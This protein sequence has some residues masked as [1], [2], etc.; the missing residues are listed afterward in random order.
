MVIWRHHVPLNRLYLQSKMETGCS[1]KT[2]ISIYKPTGCRTWKTTTW[3][4]HI[5]SRSGMWCHMPRYA[6]FGV[7]ADLTLAVSLHCRTSHSLRS[8]PFH[9]SL[10]KIISVY[11]SMRELQQSYV[12]RWFQISTLRWRSGLVVED[13]VSAYL[14]LT[15]RML[16]GVEMG[17]TLILNQ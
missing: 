13:G 5:L 3:H 6:K 1:S 17:H 4:R 15:C 2:S 10:T 8:T 12:F 14:G 9:L 11:S 7:Q 16:S